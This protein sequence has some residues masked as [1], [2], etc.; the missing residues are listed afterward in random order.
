[1]GRS[2]GSLDSLSEDSSDCS[3]SGGTTAACLPLLVSCEVDSIGVACVVA[4]KGV[5]AGLTKWE[6]LMADCGDGGV[7]WPQ[8]LA[9]FWHGWAGFQNL[10]RGQQSWFNDGWSTSRRRETN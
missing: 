2:S 4:V 1:M 9:Q 10:D 8:Q 7:C 3:A 6:W 5:M